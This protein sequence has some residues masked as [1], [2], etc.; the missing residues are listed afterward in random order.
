MNKYLL[1]CLLCHCSELKI[2][3]SLTPEQID[4]LWRGGGV[5]LSNA[6]WGRMLELDSVHLFECCRCGFQHFDPALAGDEVFYKECIEKCSGYY[7]I[8]RPENI[9]NVRFAKENGLRSILDIGCGSGFAL[10]LAKQAGLETFGIELTKSAA[11]EAEKRG[12]RVF[13]SL[14]E[15]LDAKWH[16]HFD[17]ISLNQVLEHIANP[18]AII[19]QCKSFLSENGVIS[20][21]VPGRDGVLRIN[22]YLPAN[23]PPHH[24]SLWRIADL[25][26]LSNQAGLK[27]IRFGGNQLLGSEIQSNLQDRFKNKV[28]LKNSKRKNSFITPPIVSFLYRKLALKYIFRNSGHSIFGF[29]AR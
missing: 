10:D 16:G 22:P 26:S 12:H 15:D 5:S 1:R 29:F 4:H 18:V 23:W 28:L 25:R 21:A 7:A 8:A 6:A 14:I 13:T 9:R 19:Q 17:L 20:V 11:V 27:M 2:R 3:D 24:V